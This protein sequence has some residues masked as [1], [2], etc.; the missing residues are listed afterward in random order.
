MRIVFIKLNSIR[1]IRPAHE[2]LF[3]NCTQNS[4]K[5]CR[6]GLVVFWGKCGY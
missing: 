3:I 6:W 1:L 2:K 5:I 4:A